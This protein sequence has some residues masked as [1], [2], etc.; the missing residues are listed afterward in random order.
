MALELC[1]CDM[2]SDL[3]VPRPAQVV[4]VEPQTPTEKLVRFRFPDGSDLGHKPGQF[5]QVFIP[6]IGE[7]PIS[8]C[9][10]PNPEHTF[11]LTVRKLGDVTGAIHR[12]Q[13]G[14]VV[15]IRGP[16]GN[17]FDMEAL[18]GYDLLIVG[19]GIGFVPLR[20]VIQYVAGHRD[21][22]ANVIVLYGFKAPVEEMY[23]DELAHW[24]KDC[25]MDVRLTVDRAHPDWSG[26]V[27]V[28]TTL[29]PDVQITPPRTYALVV[30]PPI[31]YQFVITE[32]RLKGLADDHIIMSLER[33]MRCGVGKCGHCQIN[34]KYVCMDGP[35]FTYSEV[36]HLWE[37]I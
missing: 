18:K 27:G 6:G 33:R 21:D 30:G 14:D 24:A 31:M 20:S 4:A 17:G 35:V 15:G 23:V 2:E 5:V 29:F 26:H 12:L 22:Y 28:I 16:F 13:P 8:I 9:S 37:A 3:Y 19:G 1:Q 10:A 11:D 34:N 7:A 32:C 36:K 25:N